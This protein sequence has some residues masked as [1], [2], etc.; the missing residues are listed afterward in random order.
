MAVCPRTKY[1]RAMVTVAVLLGLLVCVFPWAA[2]EQW[3]RGERRT[4]V[5][6]VAMACVAGIG[7]VM[8]IHFLRHTDNPW[9]WIGMPMACKYTLRGC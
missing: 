1:H 8:T 6:P 3:R 9:A 4:S 2:V 5:F 7:F